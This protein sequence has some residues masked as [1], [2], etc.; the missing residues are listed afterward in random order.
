[1]TMEDQIKSKLT[2]AF[3]PQSLTLIND[4]HRHAGHAGHD[5]SGQ[6]HFRLQITADAFSGMGRVQRQRMV[7]D[8]LAQEFKAGLHALSITALSPEEQKNTP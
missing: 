4:S 2:A 1:M 8:V 5:G 3:K 6:S 7:Y